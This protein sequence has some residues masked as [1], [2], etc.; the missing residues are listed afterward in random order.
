MQ[1]KPVGY[2]LDYEI[3]ALFFYAIIMYRYFHQRRFD[4]LKN[5]LYGFIMWIT[6]FDII[7]DILSSIIIDNVFVVPY[8]LTYIVNT[9]FYMLQILMPL[10]MTSYILAM[11]EKLSW[12]HRV[13]LSFLAAPGVIVLLLMLTNSL[14]GLV[15]Y[16]DIYKGYVHGK[17]FVLTYFF[18]LF[19]MIICLMQTYHY[20]H[21][22][23]KN[24]QTTVYQFM[25]IVFFAMLI[26]YL[27]PAFLI[28]GVAMAMSV[29]MWY[30]TLQNPDTMLDIAT[31]TFNYEGFIAYL[32]D[33]QVS[34]KN[35]HLVAIKI[36]NLRH[37]NELM[38]I[39]NG[40]ELLVQVASFLKDTGK[41]VKVFRMRGSCFV[42]ATPD[43]KE[44]EHLKQQVSRRLRSIF[45]VNNINVLVQA[46]ICNLSTMQQDGRLSTS[47]QTFF[48][49]EQAFLEPHPDGQ[50]IHKINIEEQFLAK[51]ERNHQIEVCL[52]QALESG[53]GLEIYL[54]PLW[55]IK[56]KR[57]ES[58][59]ALMRFTHPVLGKISPDEFVKVAENCGLATQLDKFAIRQVCT[60]IG[61]SALI[62]EKKLK[63]IEV[64]LSA[65]EFIHNNLA[66]NI[67]SIMQEYKIDPGCLIFE[68]T[69]TAATE[70]FDILKSC[71]DELTAAGFRFALDDFGMGY[72][73]IS[74]VL[75]LPFYMVKMDSS[76]LK[77]SEVVIKDVNHMFK[78]MHKKTV[79]E[80]VEKGE[81]VAN[82][83]KIGIDY[84]Q[85]FY[86]S[87]PLALDKFETFISKSM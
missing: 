57:Y 49:I 27:Y 67:K 11:V 83:Q 56:N 79:I 62:K 48:Y 38:G 31:D 4:N 82:A 36:E 58:A 13:M 71:M 74:Q 70:S 55:S 28:T 69:E 73:N 37:I 61:R 15:F 10:L 54:Q 24:E 51:I 72:A 66:A 65:L 21:M 6:L 2:I 47:Q 34:K 32:H 42:A 64:N 60:F 46:T 3:C 75:S 84:I 25:I 26:Q 78:S 23:T 33:Y 22:L 68:I 76:L 63:S 12:D 39:E 16:I 43:D 86:F 53:T 44:Y 77:G 20:R 35:L 59:E 87:R 29:I 41:T 14:H 1:Y 17:L 30:F 9:V 85:G 19:Y 5:R 18:C 52:R 50:L 40:N 8:A 7:F 45:K 80:G 81:Q